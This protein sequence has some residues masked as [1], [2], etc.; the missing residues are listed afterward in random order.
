MVPP[1]DGP[2]KF[3]E[4]YFIRLRRF[5]GAF[6][7]PK[8]EKTNMSEFLKDNNRSPL[9]RVMDKLKRY[10]PIGARSLEEFIK[11]VAREESINLRANFRFFTEQTSLPGDGFFGS[12]PISIGT[13]CDV[14]FKSIARNG[15]VI[16][17]REYYGYV[18][19]CDI[20]MK[21]DYD[22]AVVRGLVSAHRSLRKIEECLPNMEVT[23]VS[24][25]YGDNL[26]VVGEELRNKLDRADDY[27]VPSCKP[28]PDL[29]SALLKSS[30][31]IRTPQSVYRFLESYGDPSGI[32]FK[33]LRFT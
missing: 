22:A 7:K 32:P 18:P 23:L 31:V 19:A 1:D 24:S 11:I 9:I 29:T 33:N 14:S 20:R 2:C 15:R 28:M 3:L 27:S 17:L 16:R 12:Q 10:V 25:Y 4:S 6:L 21:E 13:G 26:R 8:K 5:T 30:N